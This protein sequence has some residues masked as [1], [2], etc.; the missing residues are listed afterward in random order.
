M[1]EEK[2]QKVY[3]ETSFVSY[4]T[5]RATMREPIVSWQAV[6]RQWREAAAI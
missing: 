3:H 6:S 4:L 5:E 1:D 2:K